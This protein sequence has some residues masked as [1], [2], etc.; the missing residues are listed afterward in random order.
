MTSSIHPREVQILTPLIIC[1]ALLCTRGSA[2]EMVVPSSLQERVEAPK[3]LERSARRILHFK[4]GG[5]QI[6]VARLVG[7]HWEVKTKEG[8]WHAHARTD[9]SRAPRESEVRRELKKR[10][11]AA[12]ASEGLEG[13]VALARW[14]AAE[15]LIE[16]ALKEAD[17]ILELEPNN[18]DT[19][20]FLTGSRLIVTPSLNVPG[21]E[22][23]EAVE[24][25]SRWA[26]NSPPAVREIAIHQLRVIEDTEAMHARLLE[27]LSNFSVRRRAFS[28]HALGRL[29]PGQDARRLLQHA[30]LDTSAGV[31]RQSAQALG[32][33]RQ[34][35]LI[36]PAVRALNSSN[37]RVRTQAAEALGF[38]GYPA[39]VEPLIGYITAAA[40]STGSG[41]RVPHGYLFVGT[42]TAYIQDFDVEVATFQAVADPQ[43]N[44][45]LEGSVLEAGVSGVVEYSYATEARAARTS[46]GRLTGA[47]P[48][49]T[50]RSWMRWWSKNGAHW[51]E[52][53]PEPTE[54]NAGS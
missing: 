1:G 47:D 52:S 37:I 14:T 33:A 53:T 48:G 45:L 15:G 10:S 29:F 23:A 24:K 5:T 27:G 43:V 21:E 31:R 44:V 50:G 18:S 17:A 35:E 34:P 32:N 9:V 19:L 3:E 41:G 30:I 28:A 7:D 49:N 6:A 36:T 13:R 46:L 39:A 25:L 8:H 4:R 40:Q 20:E 16:D 54:H 12:Q 22:L 38:M 51:M 2:Q 26:S 11:K 42:Q